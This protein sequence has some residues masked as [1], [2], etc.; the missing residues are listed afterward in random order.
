MKHYLA[1]IGSFF[2]VAMIIFAS[3]S[4]AF[5]EDTLKIND[6]KD[7]IYKSRGL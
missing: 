6:A 7:K 2:I 5:A 4:T 1:K 3:V